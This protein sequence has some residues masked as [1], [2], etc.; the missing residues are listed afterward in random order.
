MS[1]NSA[2][3]A[4]ILVVDDLERPR[5][6]L[7]SVLREAGHAVVE[8]GDGESAWKLAEK[9]MSGNASGAVN[10]QLLTAMVEVGGRRALPA[11]EAAAKNRFSWARR[12]V[13][14]LLGEAGG[15]KAFRL[16][17]SLLQDPESQVRREAIYA[18]GHFEG[19]TEALDLLEKV[20]CRGATEEIWR[21]GEAR[22]V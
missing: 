12:K 15:K 21:D 18:L 22:V 1:W 16:L 14:R 7:A 13:A 3:E 9:Q 20:L 5:R 6:A 19:S 4:T 10:V 11:L 17:D 2:P 8:A